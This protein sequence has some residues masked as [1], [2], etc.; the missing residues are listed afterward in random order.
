MVN[1]Q[2]VYIAIS[3]FVLIAIALIV[4]FVRKKKEQPHSR[5]A[6]LGMTLIVL[7]IIS[8]SGDRLICYGF[9]GVGGFLSVIDIIRNT[10]KNKHMEV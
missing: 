9:M 7:S 4:I 8:T 2:E 5:L 3:I 1:T 6:M 10:N